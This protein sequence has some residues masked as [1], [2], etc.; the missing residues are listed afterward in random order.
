LSQL[1]R[2]EIE[3]IK[4]VLKSVCISSQAPKKDFYLLI[5]DVLTGTNKGPELPQIIYLLNKEEVEERL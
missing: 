4:S 2:W 1:E 5:R 3:N